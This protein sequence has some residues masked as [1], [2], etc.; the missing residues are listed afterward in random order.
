MSGYHVVPPLL[1][2]VGLAD[3]P[4]PG[5]AEA[6]T[7]CVAAGITP[8]MVTGEKVDVP[9]IHSP[10]QELSASWVSVTGLTASETGAANPSV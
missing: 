2:L 10:D 5:V 4:R 3:P 6:V 8:V 1:G 7:Q 9:W